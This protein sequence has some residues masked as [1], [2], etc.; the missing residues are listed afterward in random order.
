LKNLTIDRVQKLK[1][2]K[3]DMLLWQPDR[4]LWNFRFH[5]K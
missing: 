1:D 2:S 3:Y 5:K 4:I